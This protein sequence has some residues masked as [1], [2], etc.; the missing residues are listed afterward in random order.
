MARAARPSIPFGVAELTTIRKPARGGV[1]VAHG[2]RGLGAV[3]SVEDPTLTHIL[4]AWQ[5]P[6]RA[7]AGA[8]REFLTDSP[9]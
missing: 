3:S 9:N 5:G 2:G 4:L 8:V 1:E 7:A 6:R